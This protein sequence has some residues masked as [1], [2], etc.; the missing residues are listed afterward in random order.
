MTARVFALSLPLALLTAGCG[1][2]SSGSRLPSA[3]RAACAQASPLQRGIAHLRNF[4]VGAGTLNDRVATDILYPHYPAAL[5]PTKVGIAP[6]R[7]FTEPVTI[8]ANYC[9]DHSPVHFFEPSRRQAA[10]GLPRPASAA[11]VREAGAPSVKLIWPPPI[12][13]IGDPNR[14]FVI[15]FDY[16]PGIVVWR[17]SQGGTVVDRLTVRV[18][19]GDATGRCRKL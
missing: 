13:S 10:P 17:F 8:T 16:K 3:D 12:E 6:H 14:W 5:F 4:D 1:H 15:P 19:V 2:H 7:R 11:V 9:A 18:C